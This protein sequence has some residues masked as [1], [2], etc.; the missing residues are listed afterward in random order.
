MSSE[1]PSAS[2][3]KQGIWARYLPFAKDSLWWLR[4]RREDLP[5]DLIAGLVTATLLVPQS[6]AYA[7]LAGL[8]PQAGLYA[9]ILP[10]IAYG[11][12]G[13]SRALSV[14]PVAIISLLVAAG[15]EPLAEPSSPEYGR[16]ALGLALEAGLIQVGVGLLRLGFLANFLSHSVVTA[17]GSA[18]ALIIAFSQLRHLLG[19]KI[20]NTE[21]FWLLLQRL[22]QNLEGVNWA[23]LGLGLLAITLLVYAQRKLP[24]QLRR[25]PPLWVL[26]LTKGAPLGAVFLTTLLVWGLNLSERAGVAVVGSI[27]AGL[28]SL[29]FPWLSWAE[30][31][32]LLPTALAI[33]LV[34]FTESYAVGQSLASQRRQKVDPNQDLVALGV[35]NLAAAVSGGYPVT[36]G[37]SRSVVNAQA[38]ANSGLAS[39]VTG[40][41]I[42]LAVI[43]LMPL[44]TFLPQTTLA[45]IVLV[46]V[47]GLVDFHPLLQ[48]WRYD[49]GDA[50]V[51]LV[52]FA[53]VLGIGVEPGIGLG[54]LVSILLFLWRASRPHIAIVGQVPGTE[55]YRN[56]LRHEVI[57]DP[58]ILAVRV[59]ESLFFAN[60]AYLQESILQEVAARPAVEQVLLVASAINFVDGSALEALAQLVERLQQMG[61]G[62]A[63]AEVKGPVMDRLKRAGFVEKVGAERFFL[64]THQAMQ[65]LK[66]QTNSMPAAAS[67]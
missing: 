47:L 26:I 36:G 45:A 55:H 35:A 50:L 33:S 38:G 5:G 65:V 15:L 62:F 1:I 3:T 10:V 66:S 39:V 23:T 31:R 42:A 20:A 9:S 44:F 32:A 61:V 60:A 6:M 41:L 28:P 2:S 7:L 27:P 49:R 8:P 22:W 14:G 12:L 11:F 51:W 57:T 53:S 24:A 54:V 34:G 63:L 21:S 13:S 25:L 67:G 40:S 29:A 58:R 18:A 56:V 16:L 17:F 46:A 52:T 64:S 59:D 43:W 37:I 30:W 48:S 4:Y 19:V